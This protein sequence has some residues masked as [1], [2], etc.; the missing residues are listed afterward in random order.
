MF[1]GHLLQ[2]RPLLKAKEKS[3]VVC[4]ERVPSLVGETRYDNYVTQTAVVYQAPT[5]FSALLQML[6]SHY[7]ESLE[8]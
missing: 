1:P 4:L 5:E 3:D 2:A 8:V 7:L 6:Y